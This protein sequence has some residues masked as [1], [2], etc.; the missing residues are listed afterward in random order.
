[1]WGRKRS[2]FQSERDYLIAL[3]LLSSQSPAC[4]ICFDWENRIQ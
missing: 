2:T 1:M 3:V 4:D